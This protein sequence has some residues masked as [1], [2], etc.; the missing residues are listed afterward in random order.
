M[1]EEKN[2]GKN[3]L[4]IFSIPDIIVHTV[5]EIY[6]VRGYKGVSLLGSD[7]YKGTHNSLL[8]FTG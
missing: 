3:N 4:Y 2:T 1:F 7:F 5:L 6:W 8:A